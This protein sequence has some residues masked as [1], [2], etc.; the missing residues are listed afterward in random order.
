M[1][2]VTDQLEPT[3]AEIKLLRALLGESAQYVDLCV[4]LRIERYAD[5]A[6]AP[7]GAAEMLKRIKAALAA[8]PAERDNG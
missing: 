5:P 7:R 8:P 4:R 3:L 2:A 6:E 1:T